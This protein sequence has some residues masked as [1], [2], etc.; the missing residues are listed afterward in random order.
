MINRILGLPD[1]AS[2]RATH[3]IPVGDKKI[4]RKR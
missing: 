1:D 4:Q 2:S 3:C